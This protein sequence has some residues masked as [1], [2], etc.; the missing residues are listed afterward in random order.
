MA[1][2]SQC[3]RAS[4]L[5]DTRWDKI[6]LWLFHHL[7]A[8][9]I[10]DLSQDKFTQG[11]SDGYSAGFERGEKM[12]DEVNSYKYK[13]GDLVFPRNG[14]PAKDLFAGMDGISIYEETDP[15]PTSETFTE[16]DS[17]I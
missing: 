10:T 14:E 16:S 15:Q 6:R 5:L 8:A 17:I 1:K 13:T 11:F 9:D 3:R 4:D 7:F 12:F 2:C